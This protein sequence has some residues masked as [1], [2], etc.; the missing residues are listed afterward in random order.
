MDFSKDH[1]Q[2]P[3]LGNYQEL[4]NFLT[5]MVVYN[6]RRVLM[7][8]T[9]SVACCQATEQEMLA[10][11]LYKGLLIWLDDLLGHETD[12]QHLLI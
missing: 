9:D 12:E 6:P 3:T 7:G 4:F 1:W 11:L 2:F 5:D 8:G 10:D